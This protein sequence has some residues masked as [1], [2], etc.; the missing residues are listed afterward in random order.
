[1]LPTEKAKEPKYLMQFASFAIFKNPPK[2]LQSVLGTYQYSENKN[3][4]IDPIESIA[5]SF[6]QVNQQLAAD[7]L[8]Q[9]KSNTP[10]FFENL[11]ADLLIN[12][13]YGSSKQDILQNSGKSGDGGIDG[14]I[15]ED[16]LGFS[17]IYIQA[18]RWN[19]SVGC[20]MSPE[21]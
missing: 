5:N 18:K 14:I 17:K 16:I 6:S 1:V 9:V 2:E 4:V 7:L 21:I 20:I 19:G 8:E 10:L 13:G 11:V 12:M 3:Q 15:K